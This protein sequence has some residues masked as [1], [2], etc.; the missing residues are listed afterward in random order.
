MTSIG[1]DL[2]PNLLWHSTVDQLT[3]WADDEGGLVIV[4]RGSQITLGREEAIDL[5]DRLVLQPVDSLDRELGT[6][7][8]G[9]L[10]AA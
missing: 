1:F 6:R 4:R 3:I 5:A 9:L 8:A 7:L 10:A 2:P